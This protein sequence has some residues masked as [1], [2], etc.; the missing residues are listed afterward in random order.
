MSFILFYTARVPTRGGLFT[1]RQGWRVF[2]THTSLRHYVQ[3]NPNHDYAGTVS[4]FDTQ[5]VASILAETDDTPAPSG[6]GQDP[7]PINTARSNTDDQAENDRHE[8]P[9]FHE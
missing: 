3:A 8:Q 1:T 2:Q 5:T 6:T 4:N 9:L 7:D